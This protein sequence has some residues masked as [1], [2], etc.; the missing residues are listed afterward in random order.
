MTD[1]QYIVWTAL[2]NGWSKPGSSLALSVFVA[3]RLAPTSTPAVLTPFDFA[4]WP[5]TLARQHGGKLRF[6]VVFDGVA[7]VAAHT[8]THK[9]DSADWKLLFDPA[10][11]AVHDWVFDD[12]TAAP[13]SSF[14]VGGVSD[15]VASLYTAVAKDDSLEFPPVSL[16]DKYLPSDANNYQGTAAWKPVRDAVAF[17]QLPTSLP[18]N[19]VHDPTFRPAVPTFDFHQTLSALLAY[20]GLLR[21]LGLVFDLEVPLPPGLGPTPTVQVQPD[22]DPVPSGVHTLDISPWTA[23]Q[24]SSTAFRAAPYG[25]DFHNGM[26][27]LQDTSRFAMAGFDADGAADRLNLLADKLRQQDAGPAS[28]S[29]GL[30]ALRTAGPAVIWH[31]FGEQPSAGKGRDL[32]G[33]F[34]TQKA[35]NAAIEAYI[36]SSG[37]TTLPTLHAE[38]VT[39]GVRFDV[40]TETEAT[41]SWRSL[42]FR[43]GTYRLGPGGTT[44]LTIDDEGASVPAVSQPTGLTKRDPTTG[45][46]GPPVPD[47]PNLYVHERIVRWR[48]WS[49]AAQRPGMSGVGSGTDLQ[50]NG[51]NPVPPSSSTT[52]E[53]P[54]LSVTFAAPTSGPGLLPKLRFGAVYRFRGRGAD[55]AGNGVAVTSNDATTATAPTAHLR[56]EPVAS[57]QLAAIAPPVPGEGTQLVV[58]L[59]DQVNPVVAN[60]RWLFPPKVPQLL[61]EEHGVLD[62]FVEGKAP[63]PDAPPSGAAATYALLARRDPARLN[64]VPGVEFYGSNPD[65]SGD[66]GVG[67]PYFPGATKLAVPWLPDP[68]ASGVCLSGVPG[69]SA[70]VTRFFEGGP[71][72]DPAPLLLTLAAGTT[73]GES[74]TPGTSTTA[75]VETITLPPGET[76]EIAVSSSLYPGTTGPKGALLGL[77]ALG[78]WQWLASSGLS[79]AELKVLEKAANA[80]LCWQLTPPLPVVLVHAVRLPLAPPTFGAPATERTAGSTKAVLVDDSFSVDSKSTSSLDFLS[81]WTDPVDDPSL[82]APTTVTMS[83]NAFKVTVDPGFKLNGS[84]PGATTQD[85]G[86][87]HHHTV[88]YTAVGTSRFSGYFRKTTTVTFSGETPVV[89]SSLG[90]DPASVRLT[91]PATTATTFTADEFVVDASAG[92]VAL[93]A[94]GVTAADGSAVEVSWIPTDT[95]AGPPSSVPV[96]S[97]AR[98]VAPVIA[99]VVP[100]W[101]LTKVLGSLTGDGLLVG[102]QGNFL[103]VYL[104][105]PWYSTGAGELLGVVALTDDALPSTAQ[106]GYTTVVGAD[107]VYDA[108]FSEWGSFTGVS[109]FNN[110]ATVPTVPGHPAYANPPALPIPEDNSHDYNIWPFAVTYDPNTERWFADVQL[111]FGT[112]DLIGDDGAYPP[113]LV[114]LALA[115]FQPWSLPGYEVSPV[116]LAT[117]A[118]P[119]PDRIVLVTE[120][121]TPGT[122]QVQV[123]GWGYVGCRPAAFNTAGDPQSG[124]ATDQD[125]PEYLGGPA[126]VVEVQMQ[127]GGSGLSGDFGWVT[128]TDT[129]PMLLSSPGNEG[130][131]VSWSGEVAL[132]FVSSSATGPLRLRIS[133]LDF[134]TSNEAPTTVDTTYRRPFVVHIP[135]S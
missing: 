38:D 45:A 134:Y 20:P 81:T 91:I 90:L 120:G 95:L 31:G 110:L 54:Q 122:V 48:G 7:T 62:G 69:S 101:Q 19:T 100:A 11:T 86:D 121:T 132:P 2:P 29:N 39:R 79:A 26:L 14:S 98:P 60:G 135:L 51:D 12:L 82:P 40:W 53:P 85:F 23:C 21:L 107:P 8:T 70:F 71:W 113:M 58:I 123:E 1:H 61:A 30:P 76:L 28:R 4:D 125:D 117:I 63:D 108:M 42:Y 84:D 104:E 73:A 105:R 97:T 3:P 88:D 35:T 124:V 115:R 25:P 112:D 59:D 75:A 34:A 83:A 93:T 80:G 87:T 41:P 119:V 67:T 127:P 49:L 131:F 13:L 89:V 24:L 37:T 68:L 9:P 22:W 47:P 99:K 96:L 56:Y 126:M 52:L 133:E 65:S 78:P 111:A 46:L 57:P 16:L 74:Y 55:L 43:N 15:L 92:S 106:L 44:T 50:D 109:S 118:Q 36:A 72:P 116:V 128:A 114:R 18:P 94:A 10:K 27:S 103:R 5:K 102:R 64:D 33:L 32:A 77:Y 6:R 66:P 129:S 17:H 130:A